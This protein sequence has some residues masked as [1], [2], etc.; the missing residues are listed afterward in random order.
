MDQVGLVL[1]AQ[2]TDWGRAVSGT[3]NSPDSG[4]EYVD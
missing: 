3:L 4:S 2:N 1:S